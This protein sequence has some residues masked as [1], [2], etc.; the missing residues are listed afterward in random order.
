MGANSVLGFAPMLRGITQN[1]YK[2]I[3]G[4]L[5]ATDAGWC[6]YIRTSIATILS[7]LHSLVL[8]GDRAPNFFV[9]VIRAVKEVKPELV[10]I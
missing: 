8:S 4:G 3:D 5:R 10:H 1:A 6:N 7:A 9:Y 2:C